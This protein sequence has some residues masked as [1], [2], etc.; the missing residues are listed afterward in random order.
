MLCLL[1]GVLT[2]EEKKGGKKGGNQFKFEL[3]LPFPFSP[4]Y[5]EVSALKQAL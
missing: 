2:G 5:I 3:W 4:A 1:N